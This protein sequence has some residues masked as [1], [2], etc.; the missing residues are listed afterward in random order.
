MT[1]GACH[2]CKYAELILMPT[3]CKY[4]LSDQV[5][6]IPLS[7]ESLWRAERVQSYREL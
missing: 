6:I 5:L 2:T 3:T 1:L 4:G 7:K